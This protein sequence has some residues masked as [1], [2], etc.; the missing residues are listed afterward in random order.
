MGLIAKISAFGCMYTRVKAAIQKPKK[1]SV[2]AGGPLTV[3]AF[4]S[5]IEAELQQYFKLIAVL[6][7]DIS[8]A[9][10]MQAAAAAATA[11]GAAAAA[12]AASA[13]AQSS[14]SMPTLR[15]LAVWLQAPY[16]RMRLLTS[17]AEAAKGLKG[18][19]LLS[20]IYSHC[21]SGDSELRAVA[22]QIVSLSSSSQMDE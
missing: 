3:E 14:S 15:R 4:C 20:T 5:S 8:R 17:L 16:Q 13:A 18:A 12:A 11:T 21:S 10:S 7:E 6:E 2:L 22:L 1:A 19:A 9:E